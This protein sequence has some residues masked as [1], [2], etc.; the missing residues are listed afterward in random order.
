MH[1]NLVNT[2]KSATTS[3][4]EMYTALQKGLPKIKWIGKCALASSFPSDNPQAKSSQQYLLSTTC[5]SL[6]GCRQG[7]QILLHNDISVQNSVC[8]S[9]IQCSSKNR[10]FYEH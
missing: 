5:K 7:L 1:T 3:T 4:E 6:V 10:N 8:I 2:T 9:D